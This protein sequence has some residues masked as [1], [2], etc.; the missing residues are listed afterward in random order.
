M[1]HAAIASR[2]TGQPE[3]RAPGVAV[4]ERIG[5]MQALGHPTLGERDRV[6]HGVAMGQGAGGR[7]GQ[8]V[9]SAMVVGM[10]TRGNSNS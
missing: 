9:A 3:Q 5:G 8:R 6:R 1:R 4:A 2:V 7:S 10:S